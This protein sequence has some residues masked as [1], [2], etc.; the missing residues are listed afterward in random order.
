MVKK[1]DSETDNF[2]R[3]KI[4]GIE[5]RWNLKLRNENGNSIYKFN[6]RLDMAKD[7]IK[8]LEDRGVQNIPTENV[9]TNA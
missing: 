2:T 3:T 5:I 4:Y 9:E 8:K 6:I 1:T 7:W